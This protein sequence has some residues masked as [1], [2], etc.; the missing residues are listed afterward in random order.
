L[1]SENI[2]KLNYLTLTTGSLESLQFL[3]LITVAI[4]YLKDCQEGKYRKLWLVLLSYFGLFWLGPRLDPTT[5]ITVLDV[6]QGDAL[7]YQLPYQQGD[8]LLDT[9]GRILWGGQAEEASID[10]NFAQKDLI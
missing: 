6:G 9:G 1:L 8:W 4:R 2:L 5:R 10:K 3:L 7:L